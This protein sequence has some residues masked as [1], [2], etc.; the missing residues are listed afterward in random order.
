[1]SGQEVTKTANFKAENIGGIDKTDV[2]IP[3]G[4]TILSGK[5]ATN[6]TS[7]LQCIAAAMGSRLA[8]LKGDANEGRIRMEYGGETYERKLTQTENGVKFTGDAYLDDPEVANLFAFLLE[9]NEARQSIGRDNALRE[10]IMQPVDTEA[11]TQEIQQLEARKEEISDELETIEARQ[12]ELTGLERQREKIHKQIKEKRDALAAKEKEIDESSR[13]IEES[14]REKD[15]LEERLDQLQKTRADLE[16]VRQNITDQRESISS[17][18]QQYRDL[19]TERDQLPEMS[20]EESER[21]EHRIS[22][23]RNRRQTLNSEI[24]DLQSLV[25][26]NEERLE[27]EG[28]NIVQTLE[29]APGSESRTA[30]TEELLANGNEEIVCWTCGSQ[31]NRSQIDETIE[32]LRTIRRERMNELNETKERL[33][34]IKQEQRDLKQ[35]K[36][37]REEKQQEIANIESEIQEREDQIDSLDDRREQLTVEV[38]RLESEVENFEAEDFD[39]ILTLHKEANQLE[40]EIDNLESELDEVTQ[41]IEAIEE[42][43]DRA[44]ELRSKYDTVVDELNA[45]RQEIDQIETNAIEEFNEH[46]DSV[47]DILEYKNIERIWIERVE[48]TVQEGR[49]KV[50]RKSFDLHIVR[51]TENGTVYEDTVVHLSE[52][53]RKVTGLI[54][55]L[56]G[57]LVHD[58]YE[59][60]PFMLLDSFEAIDADR[61]AKLIEYFATYTEYLVVA[62]LPEDAQAL[63]NEYNYVSSI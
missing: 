32:H 58:L 49:R 2:T 27:E 30:V 21:I 15:V 51:T 35:R 47:L 56:A 9:T 29:S 4:V 28:Y 20:Q 13:N 12:N 39:E 5:N 62:L 17:L 36:Q 7:F 61:I 63:D 52:S 8:T 59:T 42:L 16:T 37:R 46:M 45:K 6:R 14:Q 3:P 25:Q 11:I 10:I 34:E 31:V 33:E 44:D 50:D 41:E 24:S 48:E 43:I 40:F 38:E 57:Y 53:E 18:K 22:K 55:A 1:M 26:Y 60:V 54:F 23:L 19:K